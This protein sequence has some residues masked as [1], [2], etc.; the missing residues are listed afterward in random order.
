MSYPTNPNQCSQT[1]GP[2]NRTGEYDAKQFI[3]K[4]ALEQKLFVRLLTTCAIP[5]APARSSARFAS[6]W[7]PRAFRA[8]HACSQ[9][10]VTYQ[11][12]LE[13]A[14]LYQRFR[15]GLEMHQPQGALNLAVAAE[16]YSPFR[17]TPAQQAG[18]FG[19]LEKKLLPVPLINLTSF[20]RCCCYLCPS[21]FTRAYGLHA[22]RRICHTS[23]PKKMP[24]NS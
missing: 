18:Y 11:S 9:Q 19:K 17:M 22:I 1:I 16:G 12:A 4:M 13:L 3:K 23:A 20:F 6:F 14:E 5:A 7:L 10:V 2:T 24:S 8:L 21:P 15:Q